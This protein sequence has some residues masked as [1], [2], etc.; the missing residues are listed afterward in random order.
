MFGE[1]SVGEWTDDGGEKLAGGVSG[2]NNGSGVVEG[3]LGKVT[4]IQTGTP[5]DTAGRTV[6][7]GIRV[8][9][10]SPRISLCVHVC[11]YMTWFIYLFAMIVV[12]VVGLLFIYNNFPF[13]FFFFKTFIYLLGCD[14]FFLLER[15]YYYYCFLPAGVWEGGGGGTAWGFMCDLLLCN[16]FI[17]LCFLFLF[18]PKLLLLFLFSFGV[19]VGASVAHVLTG[20]G[21]G[22]EF[23]WCAWISHAWRFV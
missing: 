12:V 19:V 22:E 9:F 21:R 11:M 13:L 10:L 18:L 4:C 8:V 16:L 7:R 1:L 20:R 17:Y 14:V 23:K 2:N 6:K 5:L 3:A 15:L